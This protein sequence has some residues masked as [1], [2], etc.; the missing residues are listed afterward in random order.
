MRQ[1]PPATNDAAFNPA[2]SHI[3]AADGKL[4]LVRPHNNARRWRDGYEQEEDGK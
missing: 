3:S 4:D 1:A 2:S